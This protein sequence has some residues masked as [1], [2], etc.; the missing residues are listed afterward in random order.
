MPELG[1]QRAKFGRM[2][3]ERRMG[4]LVDDFQTA[5]VQMAV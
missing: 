2:A 4:G 5:V 3:Q 1:E